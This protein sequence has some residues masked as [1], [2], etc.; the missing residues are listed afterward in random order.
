[1]YRSMCVL[2]LYVY[3]YIYMYHMSCM[4]IVRERESV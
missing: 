4:T 3:I 2:I 1:M